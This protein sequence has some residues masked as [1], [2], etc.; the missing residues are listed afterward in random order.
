MCLLNYI[1]ICEQHFSFFDPDYP[2]TGQTV[3]AK[4]RVYCI[5][6]RNNLKSVCDVSEY[7]Y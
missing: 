6:L 4:S 2:T 3:N 5:Q 1:L 7:M